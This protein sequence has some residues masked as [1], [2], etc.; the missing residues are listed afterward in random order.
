MLSPL[1]YVFEEDSEDLARHFAAVEAAAV[2]TATRPAC[3][4]PG[5][6]VP[7]AAA[8]QPE[9]SLP[10][11]HDTGA[12]T[13]T[14]ANGAS[15]GKGATV[16][17]SPEPDPSGMHT[18]ENDS[19]PDATAAGGMLLMASLPGFAGQKHGMGCQH[20]AG[21]LHRLPAPWQ[22]DG[23]FGCVIWPSL[24]A[25]VLFVTVL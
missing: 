22:F 9:P 21:P 12:A 19:Q 10:A 20:S 4:P 16:Q 8:S 11:S 23:N 25:L 24:P 5:T 2:A 14:Q 18:M 1:W 17:N 3:P 13:A 6:D 15:G 7:D